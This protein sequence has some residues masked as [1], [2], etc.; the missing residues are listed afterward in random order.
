MAIMN[1]NLGKSTTKEELN[2]HIREI[3]LDSGLSQQIAYSYSSEV[4][5]SDFVGTPEPGIFDSVATIVEGNRC[6]AYVWYDN[7][8]GYSTQ[9]LRVLQHMAGLKIQ[10]VPVDHGQS[11]AQAS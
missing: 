9:V 6:V 11:F 1:L 7:E 3:S 4:V 10:D 8:F 2:D 5:S